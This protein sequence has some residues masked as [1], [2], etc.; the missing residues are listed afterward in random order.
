MLYVALLIDVFVAF[1]DSAYVVDSVSEPVPNWYAKSRGILKLFAGASKREDHVIATPAPC[2]AA[3]AEMSPLGN[4]A[5]KASTRNERYTVVAKSRPAS[6]PAYS[7]ER[8]YVAMKEPVPGAQ[9]T[10]G[11]EGR[12]SNAFDS[13]NELALADIG[14]K[15]YGR[16]VSCA[17][18][19]VLKSRFLATST[20][21][22]FVAVDGEPSRGSLTRTFSPASRTAATSDGLV[23]IWFRQHCWFDW[24][25]FDAL[26]PGRP[27]GMYCDG[28][29]TALRHAEVMGAMPAPMYVAAMAAA[30][31]ACEGSNAAG[32]LPHPLFILSMRPPTDAL[33]FCSSA[34]SAVYSGTISLTNTRPLM[35]LELLISVTNPPTTSVGTFATNSAFAVAMSC[36][37][38]ESI[39]P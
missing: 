7:V 21:L 37:P 25:S 13:K 30:H 28:N 3:T 1:I 32:L 26:K 35:V 18:L 2:S 15:L 12:R 23:R 39:S 20:I 27:Q 6:S 8:S 33:P 9:Q 10:A 17:P 36:G 34:M 11:L 4:A 5:R 19:V 22:F 24:R 31:A 29:V 14:A 16:R 38:K